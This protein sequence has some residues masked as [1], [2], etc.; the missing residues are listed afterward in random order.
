MSGYRLV[1]AD[2]SRDFTDGVQAVM[3]YVDAVCVR[4]VAATLLQTYD[5]GLVLTKPDVLGVYEGPPKREDYFTGDGTPADPYVPKPV[6]VENRDRWVCSVMYAQ[7]WID[8]I[9][10]LG[11]F[12]SIDA[13]KFA[14]SATAQNMELS[15][16]KAWERW[17]QGQRDMKRHRDQPPTSGQP[18]ISYLPGGEHDPNL[19]PKT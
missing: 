9:G 1:T 6:A 19:G 13:T 5:E 15:V 17:V 2:E 14:D 10:P 12:R 16:P 11:E 3:A 4:K 8:A 18:G 7:G